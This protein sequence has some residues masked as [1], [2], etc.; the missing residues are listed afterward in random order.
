LYFLNSKGDFFF[1]GLWFEFRAS[2]LLG[3]CSST[4]ATLPANKIYFL[5]AFVCFLQC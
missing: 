1:G 4:P 5:K 2:R 3:M